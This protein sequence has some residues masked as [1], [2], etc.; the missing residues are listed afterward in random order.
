[1]VENISYSGGQEI[2]SLAQNRQPLSYSLTISTFYMPGLADLQ[3]ELP[4]IDTPAPANKENP[5]ST[6][7][8]TTTASK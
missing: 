7:S 3:A 2:T 8:D 6:F 5:L 4:K 1:M